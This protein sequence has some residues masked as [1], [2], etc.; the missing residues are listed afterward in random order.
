MPISRVSFAPSGLTK[1]EAKASARRA[2]QRAKAAGGLTALTADRYWADTLTAI[3]KQ[4]RET[5]T[6]MLRR[7]EHLLILIADRASWKRD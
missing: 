3:A 5:A 4:P 7:T 6:E 2:Y 1:A